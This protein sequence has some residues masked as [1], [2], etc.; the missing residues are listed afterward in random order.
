M[1]DSLYLEDLKPGAVWT[2][3]GRTV[4]E[5]DI[6]SFAGLSG[7]YDPIHM[8]HEHASQTP[9]GRPIAHGMLGLSFMTGL[10]ST[11][12]LVHTLA[13]VRVA[14][15]QFL[16]PVYVGDTVH[17]VTQV[18]TITPRGRRSEVVWFR[19]LLN[20]KGECV[21]SGRI[22]TLVSSQSFLPRSRPVT[23]ARKLS[24]FAKP[25]AVVRVDS[26]LDS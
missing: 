15:W 12:P 4:T 18:E 9:Y 2:S 20:Q 5:T 24:E 11:C 17:V 19:K 22:V 3:R 21:Q 1:T 26:L 16:L 6:V 23:P 10:S 25:Q 7:D 14:D 13:L 8:D